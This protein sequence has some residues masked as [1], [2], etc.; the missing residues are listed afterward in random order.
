MIL[1]KDMDCSMPP[2][3]E[4]N[5]GAVLQWKMRNISHGRMHVVTDMLSEYDLHYTHPRIL[6][7]VLYRD[8]ATQKELADE[9]NTSPA[10]MSASVKR[11][12]KAGLIEKIADESDCRINKI[13]LTEKGRRIH[14]DTFD[15]ML[16]IDRKMVDGFS[17]EEISALFSYLDRVQKN[18]DQ[19]RGRETPA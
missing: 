18:I 11:L 12:Q 10:A 6:G 4:G 8:G 17:E 13:R 14:D 16:A 9:M 15:K 2:F 1:R 5:N 3:L 19:M 7:A